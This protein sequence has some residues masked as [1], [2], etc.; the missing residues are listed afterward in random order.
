MLQAGKALSTILWYCLRIPQP[1]VAFYRYPSALIK[2]PFDMSG[3]SLTV[4]GMMLE[5]IPLFRNL[6]RTELQALRLITQER[7][8]TAGQDIFLEGDPGNG[9][10]FVKT[11]L[12]EI[13]AGKVERRVFSRL[14]PG[15]IFGEMAVIE[16][17]PRS[18]TASAAEDAEVYFLPRG[19]MLTFIERSPG[20]AF[21]LLQQISQRLRDFNQL[22]VRELIQAESLAVIGRFAQGIVHDLKNPLNIIGIS[23]EMFGRPGISPENRA[24]SQNLIRKQVERINDMVSDILLF[25]DSQRPARTRETIQPGDYGAYIL[26]LIG[27]LRSEAELQSAR[28]EME[29]VPPAVLVRFDP[30]RL[31]RVLY[32]LVGN[33]TD[34]MPDG[35]KIFLRFKLAGREVIT[36]IEDTG[37]GLPPELGGRIFQPFATHGK[38]RGTGLGLSICKRI[39]EDHGGSISVRSEP[40]RGA[41]FAFTL[42]V[43]G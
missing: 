20:L 15:E 7:K 36:E 5:A 38:T 41:I 31:N 23:A 9:V 34:V 11:G 28:I 18:A 12:V 40:G 27:E 35:G 33:A 6:N 1:D 26:N 43:A 16:H 14:G 24:T 8:F 13:S 3:F 10:Y 37:P 4:A 22:H 29:Q 30:R 17:R 2:F 19:E 42:P 21:A 39:V 25:T 32:N